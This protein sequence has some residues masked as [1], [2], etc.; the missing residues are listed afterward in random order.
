MNNPSC[1]LS[2]Y[3]PQLLSILRIVTALLF[4][5]HG[6]QKLFGFPMEPMGGVTAPL[7]SKMGFAGC[8]ELF[9]GLL[10]LLG[11]FT[12][13]VAFLLSGMMAVAYFSVHAKGGWSPLVNKGELAV[14]YCFVFFYFFFAGGGAWSLDNV[15]CR[16]KPD[17]R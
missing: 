17:P 13:P 8:L 3:A 10:F 11:L 7:M 14:L 5:E 15:F 4:M 1:G 6:G 9:G 12:R 2:K 16:K